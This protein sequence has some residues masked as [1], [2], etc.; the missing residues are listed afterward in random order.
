MAEEDP[1][2]KPKKLTRVEK[3]RKEMTDQGMSEA[4]ADAF[5]SLYMP[6]RRIKR[7]GRALLRLDKLR[8]FLLTACLVIAIIF[9]LAFMQEKAGNFTINL[10]RL[11]LYR[12]GIAIAA[13]G[14]FTRPTARLSASAVE[15][16]TNI[17]VTDLPANLDEIDGD[18][19]G[20][21][22][23]AYTYYVRNAGKEDVSYVATLQLDASSKGAENAARVAVW[24]NGERAVYAEPSRDGSP[25]P[26]CVNFETRNLVFSRVEENFLVGNVDKYTIAIWLEGE[27]PECVD[28]I[29]G[30]SIEFSMNIK[31]VSTD[32]TNLFQKWVM[33]LLDTLRGNNP[34]NP[35][36]TVSPEFD[37]RNVTWANRRNQ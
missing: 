6:A 18:H 5:V 21:N 16:A 27:D 14:D 20:A 34:I 30:G 2:K 7:L 8:L 19:S 3:L 37:A 36:G 24:H 23:M 17:T 15:D 10:D 25:E 9:I 12:K 13:D 1:K 11:E 32:D 28:A 26:G 29:V 31:A 35:A 33:D 4:D 22:Y